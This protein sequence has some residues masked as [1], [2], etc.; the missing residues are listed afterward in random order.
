M[1]FT[2]FSSWVVAYLSDE[3]S[4]KSSHSAPGFVPEASGSQDE[5]H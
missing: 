2:C 3:G 5:A 1:G 4:V